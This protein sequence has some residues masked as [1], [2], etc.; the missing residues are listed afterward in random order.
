MKKSYILYVL[1]IF[2]FTECND[3]DYTAPYGDFSSFLWLTSKGFDESDYNANINTFIGFNDLSK[4]AV[5][6]TWSIPSGTALLENT[7]SEKDS[8]YT[9]FIKGAGPIDVKE[10]LLNVL[11]MESGI[12]EILLKNVFKD[13]VAESVLQQDGN[14]LV[15]KT[16]TVTVFD[17]IQPAFQILKGTEILLN[18][19]ETNM[20]DIADEASWQTLTVE[21][22]EELTFVDLTTVG[23]PNT[24]TWTFD[25]GDISTSELD[26]VGVL[27]NSLGSYSGGSIISRRTNTASATTLAIKL[28]PVKIEVVPSTQPFVING[29]IREDVTEI[30]SFNV[31]GEVASI[32]AT[33]NDNFTVSVTN[34]AANFNQIIAVESVSIN[35]SNLTQIDLKLASPIFNTD[36]IEITYTQGNIRSVD[37]RT[38]DSFSMQTVEMDFQGAMNLPGYTGYETEWSG[39]GNQFRKANTEG[40]FAQHNGTSADGPLYYYR[41]DSMA[42]EGNSSMKFETPATGIPNLARLQGGQFGRL[43]PVDAG[44]YIPSVWV[45]IDPATTMTNFQYSFTA[46]GDGTFNF[47]ISTTEKGQ[48][49]RL[50]LPEVTLPDLSNGRLDINVTQDGQNDAIVQKLW[51]DNFDLLIL[52]SR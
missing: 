18:I 8:I 14:W 16:F 40:F 22:G 29:D 24:R 42:Y 12:K 19:D 10:D 38:L 25:G 2:L 11:F 23:N 32:G 39:S 7:F 13:S 46:S 27:Y 37:F 20:P 9:N 50:T 21:A 47:D 31:T 17:D 36:V 49:V 6:Q 30:I 4:N 35:S 34:T 44:T 15:E 26:S 43:S 1:I 33:E 28:I 45:F 3:E 5:S 52:E 41:D 48:W 51:L